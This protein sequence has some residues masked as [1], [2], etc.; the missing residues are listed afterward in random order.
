[1]VS[2]GL[3]GA[4]LAAPLAYAAPLPAGGPNFGLRPAD[5]KL[6]YFTYTLEP[7]G[8][9]Q[10]SVLAI[11]DND[12]PLPLTLRKATGHTSAPGGVA[13]P[14]GATVSVSNWVDFPGAGEITVPAHQAEL[15]P[16]SL[17]VPAGT[18]PGEYVAGFIAGLTTPPTNSNSQGGLAIKIVPEAAV[19]VVVTV[20]G[21]LSY[22][23]AIDGTT[24]GSDGSRWTVKVKLHNLGNA[25]WEGTGHLPLAPTQGG[26]AVVDS[27][28]NVG[29]IV[30]GDAIAYPMT[31][32]SFPP[33]DYTLTIDLNG[34][35]GDTYHYV[36]QVSTAQITAPIPTPVRSNNPVAS[37]TGPN[38]VLIVVLGLLVIL[39]VII[40][41]A[42]IYY[43]SRSNRKP[44]GG[45]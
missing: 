4:L 11:N 42:A 19:A 30:A 20:P 44:S 16:F 13:F 45:A 14:T 36:E 26:P 15:L 8:S 41:A 3:L 29:Y 21:D 37:P 32:E 25:G 1:M 27:N 39:A 23:L 5:L 7:G 18:P 12:T 34:K 43:L 2:L 40:L 6:G 33:A 38:V 35:K 22:K 28:F 9:I 24:D 31:F 17:K 10:D